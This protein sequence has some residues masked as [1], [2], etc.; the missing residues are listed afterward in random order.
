MSDSNFDN[1]DLPSVSIVRVTPEITEEKLYSYRQCYMGIS[2]DNPVFQ[3]K[4]LEALLVWAAG[5][6]DTC[7]VVTG[8]YLRRHN[9]HMLNGLD[10]D[11]AVEVAMAAGDEFIERA[12]ALFNEM[13]QD[14]ISLVRWQECLAFEE[15]KSSKV[16][17]EKLLATDAGFK[18]AVRRD[19]VSFIKRQT[20]RNRNLAVSKDEAVEIS[21]E[22]LL[23]EIAVF[24]ALSERG[25]HVELYPGPELEVLVDIADGKFSD[26][27][28]GL[29][30]RINVEL[31][32][33]ENRSG[34]Q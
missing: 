17:L 26:I 30:E 12:G 23:E 18:R 13:P 10:N 25:R 6:F 21:C 28:K 19:A 29:K 27:P 14:K 11:R 20:Q 31:R 4:S 9:E 22:Y 1:R 5:R 3:G 7:L 34:T 33:S 8:D 15:Y 32:C 24:S 16:M 2:L